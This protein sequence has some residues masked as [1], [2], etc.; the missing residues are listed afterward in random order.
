MMGMMGMMGM[1]LG[2][3]SLNQFDMVYQLMGRN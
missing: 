1:G 2:E 3:L